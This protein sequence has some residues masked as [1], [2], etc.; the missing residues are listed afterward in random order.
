MEINQLKSKI[1]RYEHDIKKLT[2][3]LKVN[4]DREKAHAREISEGSDIDMQ[5]HKVKVE[6]MDLKKEI[7]RKEELVESGENKCLVVKLYILLF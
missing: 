5:V 2:R 7:R 1:L 6:V 4:Q 3:Q